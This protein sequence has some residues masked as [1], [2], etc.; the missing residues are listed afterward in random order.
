MSRTLA[1]I[2][3]LVAL[4]I[5]AAIMV[6]LWRV[7]GE[8]EQRQTSML[9]GELQLAL[10]RAASS[11]TVDFDGLSELREQLQNGDLDNLDE[12]FRSALPD[13]SN[14]ENDVDRL[15]QER[16]IGL[17]SRAI[18]KVIRATLE[19]EE[20]Y[21]EG[22]SPLGSTTDKSS[23]YV[24]AEHSLF[25]DAG[26]LSVEVLFEAAGV[27][28]D[29]LLGA[30][31]RQLRIGAITLAVLLLI[32]LAITMRAIVYSRTIGAY[33]TDLIDT[34]AHELHT[35]LTTLHIG[36]R[37]LSPNLDEE[38]TEIAERLQRQIRRL[39][40][41]TERVTAS[42]RAL[43]HSATPDLAVNAPDK[44]IET[45]LGERFPESLKS[46]ILQ[47]RL[48]ADNATILADRVDLEILIGNLVENALKFAS[49]SRRTEAPTPHV[50]VSTTR[51]QRRLAIKI[52]DNGP[53]F[54]RKVAR[55]FFRPFRRGNN[56]ASGLGLGLY[57]CRRIARRMNGRLSIGRSNLGGA[58][59]SVTIPLFR[60]EVD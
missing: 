20:L 55:R 14:L 26:G 12:R 23:G 42:S 60:K 11:H 49:D 15:L 57:L 54:D 47:L 38:G 30:R 40:R 17:Q 10:S 22:H 52:D 39:Q 7:A 58:C 24:S 46:G 48:G 50:V 6:G 21:R 2:A 44:E 33:Q 5:A 9:A 19:E 37:T 53:G 35:P 31:L 3:F 59:A 4:T 34:L 1:S 36:L 28:V 16:W 29:E 8:L 25:L 43:L 13:Y 45:L 51:K 27:N 41:L 56:A 32:S 18:V